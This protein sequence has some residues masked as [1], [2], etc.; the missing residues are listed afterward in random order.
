MGKKKKT[1]KGQTFETGAETEFDDALDD[2]PGLHVRKMH[3]P[4]SDY[5]SIQFTKHPDGE[6]DGVQLE[7]VINV[8][9]QEVRRQN[10]MLPAPEFVDV[11]KRLNRVQRV[12]G[13]RKARRKEEGT[14]GTMTP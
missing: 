14:L 7:D 4:T 12:L 3:K 13:E 6:G 5:I 11:L 10:A 9:S 8:L 1:P 2:T